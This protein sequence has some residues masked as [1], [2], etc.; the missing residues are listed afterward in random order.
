MNGLVFEDQSPV[1]SSDPN[2]ADIACF[3]GFIKRRN[4]QIPS[5]V[6][7][8]L[9]EQ[10]WSAPPFKRE[11]LP[12]FRP[13]DL[14]EADGLLTRLQDKDDP[15]SV[16]L[17]QRISVEAPRLLDEDRGSD[18]ASE[19]LKTALLI[20]LN[21][22][23]LAEALY[24]EERFKNIAL[25]ASTKDKARQNPRGEN[26][27]RVNRLLLEEAFPG[28]IAK[29]KP[30]TVDDLL[31]IPVPIDNWE[32][33]DRLFAWERRDLDGRGP[34]STTYLGAAV[35][36]FFAQGGRKC[37]VVRVGDPWLLMARRDARLNR[38]KDLIPGY[39]ISLTCSPEDRNS[40]SGIGHL[41][42][43][44][45]VSFLCL[46][47]LADAVGVDR[48]QITLPRYISRFEEQ[49]VECSEPAPA[50]PADSL[51]RLFS[52][53]R[54]GDEEYKDWANA[55]FMATSMLARSLREVQMVASVP[56]PQA[57][58]KPDMASKAERDLM[59]FFTSGGRFLSSPLS[60]QQT[61]LSSAFLQLAYPWLRTP[62]SANLPEQIES[63]EAVLAGLLARNA[64]TRGAFRSA[65]GFHLADVYDLYP[66]LPRYQMMKRHADTRAENS[67][68]HTLMERVSLFG[69]TPGGFKLLSDVTTSLN[70]SYRPAS[71]NRLVSIII[72]AARRLGEDRVFESSGERLWAEL[73]E[74]LNALLSGL[75]EAGALRG[76][77]PSEAFDV[78]C[79]R[80]TMTQND[81]DSGRVI[82]I[83][84]FDAAVPIERIT[85]ALA[86]DEG[87]QVSQ[88]TTIGAINRE[89]A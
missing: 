56:I 39:P 3:V 40:W 73:K 4:T 23:I 14:I 29:G 63:P 28:E 86:M 79:D 48:E 60:R 76:E 1:V 41:F 8:W 22:V 36:S 77:T 59:E 13:G 89:A 62:G 66:A 31:D 11:G 57:G 24:D 51:A 16:Y 20:A 65:A 21:G 70:E 84:Q 37:Y 6:N 47:D 80:S 30:T 27:V 69:I 58:S 75:L 17:K 32:V 54:C 52:A 85:V 38:I 7:R 87:G 68:L 35:R 64:L 83:V 34:V 43:L 78:R 67:P 5:E 81:I 55:L 82:A 50:P 72:R 46:P 10:G 2:R 53:P 33:F 9:F 18:P 45:D 88:L 42:G 61:G 19:S 26:L 15:L 12:L 74:G 44:P 49:F 71:V 25:T